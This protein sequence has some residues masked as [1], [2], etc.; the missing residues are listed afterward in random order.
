MVGELKRC[1]FEGQEEEREGRRR[2]KGGEMGFLSKG[3]K[4]KKAAAQEAAAMTYA[5]TAHQPVFEERAL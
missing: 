5:S 4:E 2:E 1:L 3:R